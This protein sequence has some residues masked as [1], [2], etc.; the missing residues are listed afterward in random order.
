MLLHVEHQIA[1]L[2]GRVEVGELTQ[3]LQLDQRALFGQIPAE[4]TNV[5]GCTCI[6]ASRDELTRFEHVPPGELAVKTQMHEAPGLQ[7][8]QQG[9]PSCEGFSQMM[10]HSNGC[11]DVK[12]PRNVAELQ[13]VGL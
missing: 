6:A 8:R 10:Q 13:Y 7:S 9:S 1:T 11:D 4:A 3:P 5:I 12:R 2:A